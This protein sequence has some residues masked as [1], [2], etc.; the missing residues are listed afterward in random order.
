MCVFLFTPLE[1]PIALSLTFFVTVLACLEIGFRF[2]KHAD[3]I[4]HE[5][6]HE[7][8]STIEAAVFALLGLLIAFTFGGATARLDARRQMI[9]QEANAI[10]TAYLRLDLLPPADQPDMRRWMRE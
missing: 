4:E 9:V 6:A 7:G 10:G 8:T 1:W 5:T 3:R 2:G